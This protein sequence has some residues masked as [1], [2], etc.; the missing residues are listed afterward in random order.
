MAIV[1]TDSA[2]YA[3]IARSI[4]AKNGSAAVYK[5]REMAAAIDAIVIYA[6]RCPRSEPETV[7]VNAAGA[8]SWDCAASIT[9]NN[10]A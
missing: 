2:N 5:P 6:K 8:L 9:I 10:Q 1:L 4:R 7:Y 3:A